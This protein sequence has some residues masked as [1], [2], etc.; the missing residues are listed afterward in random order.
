MS[1]PTHRKQDR[2]AD[3]LTQGRQRGMNEMQVRKM[4]R[5]LNRLARRVLKD[6]KLRAGDRVLDV[7]A[8]TGLLALEARRRVKGSGFV[9]ASDISH[10]ALVHCRDGAAAR[11]EAATFV[12]VVGDAGALPF[13]DQV[14]DAVLTRSVLIYLKDKEAGVRELYRVL[15]T[16]G[17][18]S[19]FEPINQV[20]SLMTKRLRDS[21]LFDA[22]QP[23]YERLLGD[24][25]AN[26]SSTFLGWDERDLAR[27]FQDAG[28][29]NVRL[30]YEYVFGRPSRPTRVTKT[31][32]QRMAASWQMRPNPHALSFEELVRN[33]LGD[34]ADAFLD[35]FLEFS[36]S[37]P[38]PFAY[39][40]AYLSG[41]R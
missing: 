17:R 6:A 31:A 33:E 27:W 39:A 28:F 19:V 35:R 40:V 29:S 14:F 32:R 21:G 16:G 37:N 22:F 5:D 8:G 36:L 23:T 12:A 20:W 3:W 38:A 41:R 15:K 4:N 2:W 11:P 18:V 10:D 1:K 25:R 13:P 7:G 26:E 9:V 30:N 24:S 34:E